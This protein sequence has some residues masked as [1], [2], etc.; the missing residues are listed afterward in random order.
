MTSSMSPEAFLVSMQHSS[1]LSW[2]GAHPR[3]VPSFTRGPSTVMLELWHPAGGSS[4][5]ARFSTC[6]DAN[7]RKH[8]SEELKA[9]Y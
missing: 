2:D 8:Q 6:W 3:S 7:E 1:R 5:S 4:R 9:F